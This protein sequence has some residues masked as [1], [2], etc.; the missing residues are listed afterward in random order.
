MAEPTEE[1]RLDRAGIE[2]VLGPT[3]AQLA[4]EIVASGCS[5]EE[6]LEAQAWVAGDEALVNEHR[7]FPTGRVAAL[8]ELLR[9]AEEA[10]E[11]R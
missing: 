10:E 1:P 4:A 5:E 6:L 3:D 8:V 9:E 2:R 7:P 11:E